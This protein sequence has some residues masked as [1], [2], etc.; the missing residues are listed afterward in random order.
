MLTIAIALMVTGLFLASVEIILPGTIW[1]SLGAACIIGSIVTAYK[2]G[3]I[4]W[5]ATALGIGVFSLCVILGFGIK[6]LPKM[7]WAKKYFTEA[8]RRGRSVIV[9]D[10]QPIL[11][12]IGIV[13]KP[14]KPV[15]L[16]EIEGIHYKAVLDKGLKRIEAG[17]KV[18]V[19]GHSLAKLVVQAAA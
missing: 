8:A 4:T 5:G 6:L 14:L 16:I 12:K 7:Q 15:G 18:V 1:G 10:G 19:V 13:A 9:H 17:S 3:G 2:I 11:G